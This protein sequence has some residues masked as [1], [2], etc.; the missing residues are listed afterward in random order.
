MLQDPFG[1]EGVSRSYGLEWAISAGM[2]PS[3]QS[4]LLGTS[5]W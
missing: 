2:R 3:S 1:P 5:E 4:A